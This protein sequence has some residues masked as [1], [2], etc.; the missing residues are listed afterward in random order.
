MSLILRAVIP[1]IALIHSP[2]FYTVVSNQADHFKLLSANTFVLSV[3]YSSADNQEIGK[4]IANA[5]DNVEKHKTVNSNNVAIELIDTKE[6]PFFDKHYR[7]NGKHGARL[8]IKGQM[9]EM[10]HFNNDVESLLRQK[11]SS[12]DMTE[13]LSR[14]VE[15]QIKAISIELLS[16][17]QFKNILDSEKTVGFFYGANEKDYAK[18]YKVALKNMGFVF[19]HTMD[20][21]IASEVFAHHANK[22]APDSSVFVI[23]RSPEILNE[24]DNS[25]AVEFTD[26]S[27]KALTEFIEYEKHNKLRGPSDASDI[28]KRIFKKFQPLLLYI[29]P[30]TENAKDFE[31]FKSA[32]QTLPKRMIY[33]Y[34]EPDEENSSAFMQLFLMNGK[35][36]SEGETNIIWMGPNRQIQME[37]FTGAM[38]KDMLVEFV[39]KF[40]KQNELAIN[41]MSQHFYE[42]EVDEQSH[43]DITSEEL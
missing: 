3:I 33:A 32:I 23:I 14:F 38:D 18:Y 1:L 29:K 5:L 4:L 9:A 6:A 41:E 31:T 43:A 36:M 15:D 10:D 17:K 11:I 8:F 34:G 27:E 19:T 16:Y 37:K 40:N 42:K 22:A 2:A 26:F 21:Q 39:F 12:K 25:T 30:K 28:V 35:N 13:K 7:L 20:K 24:F